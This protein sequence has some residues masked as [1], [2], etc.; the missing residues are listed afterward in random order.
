MTSP[1]KS[2]R[3][4]KLKN[5]MKKLLLLLPLFIFGCAPKSKQQQ[6]QAAVKNYVESTFSNPDGYQSISFTDFRP[7]KSLVVNDTS[8]QGL[9]GKYNRK[10]NDFSEEKAARQSGDPNTTDGQLRDDSLK[11]D[12]DRKKIAD[13]QKTYKPAIVGWSIAHSFRIKDRSGVLAIHT[14]YFEL[15][16]GLTEVTRAETIGDKTK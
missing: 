4:L 10:L 1:K 9:V 5:K 14:M 13:F 11:V 15:D 8:Y 3:L 6:A 16:S 12:S 7:L 2:I